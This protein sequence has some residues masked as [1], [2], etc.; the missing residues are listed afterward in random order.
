MQNEITQNQLLGEYKAVFY[1][2]LSL[3]QDEIIAEDITQ[4]TFMRALK[5]STCYKGK[6]SLYTWLCGIAK[7]IWLDYL[8]KYSKEQVS[9][10]KIEEAT[11]LS[12]SIEK[13]LINKED[14]RKIHRVL[15]ELKEPYK[16]VFSL[17]VFGELQLKEISE[18]FGKSESWAR[19]TYHRAVKLIL[20]QLEGR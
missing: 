13:M 19:V 7:H 6:S 16:E 5:S 3:T 17:R 4:E 10:L 15:H 2:V 9:D 20:E 11:E 14:T 12:D 18:L 8:K 1:Y